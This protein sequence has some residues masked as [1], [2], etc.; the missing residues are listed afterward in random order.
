MEKFP[1]A[2]LRSYDA[3]YLD[4]CHGATGKII[5]GILGNMPNTYIRIGTTATLKNCDSHQY[6]V[7][8][9]FGRPYQTITVREL[10]D[11]GYASTVNIHVKILKYDKV[12]CAVVS[13]LK[14]QNEID[15][16]I[17]HMAR[18]NY[19]V[20]LA[21]SLTGLTLVLFTKVAMH[22]KPLYKA[23]LSSGVPT[24]YI[25]GEIKVKQRLVIS[26]QADSGG[27][28]IL[29]ASY[30]T[31]STGI[32]VKNINNIIFASPYKSKIKVLQSIGRALRI[33]NTDSTTDTMR[34][35]IYDIADDFR[36][37]S[38]INTTYKHLQER[39]KLYVDEEHT[40]DIEQVT[41]SLSNT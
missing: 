3:V 25:S 21:G 30:G 34:C 5:K 27:D 31:F 2:M 40:Y 23:L 14:Y 22:G 1:A 26:E 13:K 7:I 11:Q 38:K 33:G 32:S 28:M 15:Y 8:S 19:I 4:E 20:S 10:M 18:T 35:T 41:C 37:E 29:V 9:Q 24:E 36:N 6:E 16:L 39:L 17:T 12:E